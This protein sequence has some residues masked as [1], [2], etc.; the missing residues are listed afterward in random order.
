MRGVT[1]LDIDGNSCQFSLSCH[2]VKMASDIGIPR[3]EKI[4]R[5]HLRKWWKQVTKGTDGRE[6]KSSDP[7][8][9]PIPPSAWAQIFSTNCLSQNE[10]S[11]SRTLYFTTNRACTSKSA[12]IS[13]NVMFLWSVR[14]I[15]IKNQDEFAASHISSFPKSSHLKFSVRKIGYRRLSFW[16]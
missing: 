8:T 9:A 3:P 5:W 6:V 11:F 1:E 12:A 7:P 2:P 14:C 16:M 4:Y 13:E 10:T 15:W